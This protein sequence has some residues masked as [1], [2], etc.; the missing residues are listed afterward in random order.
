MQKYNISEVCKLLGLKPYIIR[1]WEREI[2]FLS[3]QKTK[4]GRRSFSDCD[5]QLLYRIRHLL[6]DKKYT[7]EGARN[8]IWEEI[9]SPK[10]DLK[11]K[12]AE[13]RSD[14]VEVLSKL[15]KK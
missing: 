7:I 12:I 6:Y 13:I 15:K 9:N 10:V 2:P 4:S 3:P 1:Y 14:L 5:L 11:S 8:R